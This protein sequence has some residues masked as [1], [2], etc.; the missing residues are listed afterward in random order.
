MTTEL[1]RITFQ[2]YLDIDNFILIPV[3]ISWIELI[4]EI[5]E[6]TKIKLTL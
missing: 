3:E 4:N 5:I 1:Y 6:S 2:S